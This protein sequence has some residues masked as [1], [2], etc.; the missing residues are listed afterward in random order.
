MNLQ[1]SMAD[2]NV[3]ALYQQIGKLQGQMQSL[4]SAQQAFTK[5]M[6]EMALQISSQVEKG[7]S[8]ADR[9]INDLESKLSARTEGADELIAKNKMAIAYLKW[10]QRLITIAIS[11]VVTLIVSHIEDIAR[12]FQQ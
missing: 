6:H 12:L 8:S 1:N 2:E 11:S 4:I 5:Q 7:S 9:R 10:E 3:A